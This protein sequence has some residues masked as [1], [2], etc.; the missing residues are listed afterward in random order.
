MNPQKIKP[1]IH[2]LVQEFLEENKQDIFTLKM[3][4]SWPVHLIFPDIFAENIEKFTD[5]LDELEADYKICFAHK[6]NKSDAFILEAKKKN[7]WVDVASLGELQHAVSLGFTWENI[8]CSG[9]K[10]E[11]FLFLALSHNALISIDSIS[12]LETLIALQKKFS[13]KNPK[14][15]IRLND[16]AGSDR[17][18]V[19]KYTKFWI[20]QKNI[21]TICEKAKN[22]PIKIQGIHFH[23]DESNPEIKAGALENAIE[24]MKILHNSWHTP[25]IIDIW[26]WYR[27]KELESFTDWKQYIDFLAEKKSKNEYSY[28]WGNRAYW[29]HINQRW[30]IEGREIVSNRYK[31]EEA[32]IFLKKML[33]QTLWDSTSLIEKVNDSMFSLYLEPGYSLAN[34]TGVSFIKII[35][36]KTVKDGRKALILDANITNFSSRM[37]EYFLD[38]ILIKQNENTQKHEDSYFLFGHLCRDDDILIQREIHFTK[39]PEIW[40]IIC[41]INT[42]SYISDFEDS[43]PI[44]QVSGKKLVAKKYKNNFITYEDN[45]Q[46]SLWF[47][48]K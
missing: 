43:N 7:I 48:Q 13:F 2:P 38:P 8:T 15:M 19:E 44:G 34:N 36:I 5:T 41:L 42:A 18:L 24:V 6:V 25:N 46:N 12:E 23:F 30:G 45:L 1:F 33:T 11:S 20:S 21:E 14:I 35:A 31:N 37:W 47:T 26:W 17:K 29:L 3:Q 10:S 4:H 9:P 40:D 27:G 32:E 16:L 22:T 28:T 39:K